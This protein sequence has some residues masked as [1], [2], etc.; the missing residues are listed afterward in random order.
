MATSG[1]EFWRGE[2]KTTKEEVV[3]S[4]MEREIL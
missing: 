1:S 2:V 4:A 3:A